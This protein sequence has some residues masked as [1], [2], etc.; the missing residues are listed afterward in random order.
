MTVAVIIY[1]N[2]IG[3]INRKN[4]ILETT[5]AGTQDSDGGILEKTVF[6]RTYVRAKTPMVVAMAS[7]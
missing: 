6:I 3:K 7:G 5:S 4:I 1:Q 2:N